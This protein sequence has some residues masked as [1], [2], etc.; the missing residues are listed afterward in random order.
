MSMTHIVLSTTSILTRNLTNEI[1][2]PIQ[3]LHQMA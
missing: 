3:V 2:S 1:I